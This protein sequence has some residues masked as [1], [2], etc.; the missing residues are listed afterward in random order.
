MKDKHSYI[1]VSVVRVHHKAA[2]TTKLNETAKQYIESCKYEWRDTES[3]WKAA[4]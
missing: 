4:L 2:E 1:G 3:S